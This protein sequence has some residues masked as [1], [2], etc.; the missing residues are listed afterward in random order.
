MARR[1]EGW[2]IYKQKRDGVYYVRF[3]NPKTGERRNLS[4]GQ[5]VRS[6]AQALAERIYRS[7]LEGS[8]LKD[9]QK[10]SLPLADF[11]GEWLADIEPTASKS[12]IEN[13]E[14][15]ARHF[16]SHFKSIEELTSRSAIALY[17]S[18]RLKKVTRSTVKKELS[19]LR[20]L[21]KWM[22]EHELLQELP[23][24][25]PP[26]K[27]EAGRRHVK[28]SG[29]A[30]PITSEEVARLLPCLPLESGR[31][32]FPVR[33]Y[34]QLL[35]ETGLRPKTIQNLRR[36]KHF[37]P[38]HPV[39]HIS[40][41]ID[42]AQYER[43]VDLTEA[44]FEAL[45]AVCK[46]KRR[47]DL[48]FGRYDGRSA[49]RKAALDAGLPEERANELKPYSFR[50]GRTTHLVAHS[51]NMPGVMHL[52]GHK[53]L[54]TTNTYVHANQRAGRAVLDSLPRMALRSVR[55]S[56]GRAANNNTG[57]NSGC[58]HD[59]QTTTPSEGDGASASIQ[60]VQKRGLEPPRVLPHQILSLA[61]LPIPPLLRAGGEIS[62]ASRSVKLK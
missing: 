13:Y 15:Y 39:L 6:E 30:E 21:H 49:L 46:G 61:R 27:S 18:K 41:D 62:E 22:Y 32:K 59:A 3:T 54:T 14:M 31:V 20:M 36:G 11:L 35:W 25:A 16:C 57:C 37:D 50:H 60:G 52:V 26:L 7:E 40:A 29:R 8:R 23:I 47:G 58:S 17:K 53:H 51:D 24:V 10:L 48:I 44:G 56:G 1:A 33:H 45:K 28:G 19:C 5:T 43:T 12:K 38:E 42:K 55:A 4:T 2:R 34:F 9:S